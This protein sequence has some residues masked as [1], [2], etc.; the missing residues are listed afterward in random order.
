M[1]GGFWRRE[2]DA[3][4]VFLR[5]VVAFVILWEFYKLQKD[6]FRVL[7]ARYY[8][9]VYNLKYEFAEAWLPDVPQYDAMVAIV[10]TWAVC[11]VMVAVGYQY[12][13]AMAT[14]SVLFSFHFFSAVS[15]YLNHHYLIIWI[16]ASFTLIPAAQSWSI[17]AYLSTGSFRGKGEAPRWVRWYLSSLMS[18]LYLYGSVAKI[19]VD[20]LRAA[21]LYDWLSFQPTRMWP[22][23][24]PI[25]AQWWWPYLISY[26][27]IFWDGAAPF[28]LALPGKWRI[29]GIWGS[30]LF[31]GYNYLQFSIGVFP[32]MSIG[33][34]TVYFPPD[35][36]Q[37]VWSTVTAPLRGAFTGK[38][39]EVIERSEPVK[40]KK[41][42]AEPEGWSWYWK[43]I[44]VVCFGM[45]LFQAVFPARWVLYGVSSPAWS[46]TGH[47]YSC[48][49]KLR[50]RDVYGEYVIDR[51]FSDGHTTTVPYDP[52]KDMSFNRIV[53]E[54]GITL[55][56]GD[57]P[58]LTIRQWRSF[59]TRPDSL[60]RFARHLREHLIW[61]M[62][63]Y[64][65]DAGGDV[66]IRGNFT[67]ELNGRPRAPFIN[68]TVILSDPNLSTWS[69][70]W[71]EPEPPMPGQFRYQYPWVFAPALVGLAEDNVCYPW[72]YV[73]REN[74]RG[75]RGALACEEWW[76]ASG[77]E[78]W[79]RYA[80]GS[81]FTQAWE[82]LHGG[83]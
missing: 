26:G 59:K 55:K 6:D 74:K 38:M 72:H 29:L 27:G 21:P 9:S 32:W 49:M 66:R 31:H 12:H 80:E 18:I 28:L 45:F 48:R 60:R 54:N 37:R 52:T 23:W 13:L 17:D 78:E 43:V 71:I 68:D 50:D 19:N 81:W 62:K 5:L 69:E 8:A 67:V 39:G 41:Q 61:D 70:D 34:S 25:I 75:K 73:Q 77:R 65:F 82:A 15:E 40:K 63:Q 30:L 79:Q 16:G 76:N 1:A 33:Y 20:W 10:Y 64:A 11:G 51:V 4:L 36:P 46:D 2:S 14:F 42:E 56:N 7:H 22:F 58:R 57:V 53:D 83:F 44:L 24:K 47:R 35:W 3:Y